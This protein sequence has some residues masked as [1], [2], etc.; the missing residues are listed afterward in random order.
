MQLKHQLVNPLL[1]MTVELLRQRN[2]LVGI[3]EKKDK[4]IRDYKDNGSVVSRSKIITNN[5][6]LFILSINRT[7]GD[8]TI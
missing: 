2:R 8:D 7:F 6:L 5:Y 3:I 1:S 4:E